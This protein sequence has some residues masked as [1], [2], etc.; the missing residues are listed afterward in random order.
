MA[1]TPWAI[2]KLCLPC[3][4]IESAPYKQA[5]M[6]SLTILIPPL[7]ISPFLLSP[8][9]ILLL[10]SSATMV[11]TLAAW[12]SVKASR[13]VLKHT[14]PLHFP[15]SLSSCLRLLIKAM[16]VHIFRTF[17]FINRLPRAWFSSTET[18]FESKV[19][20]AVGEPHGIISS[21]APSSSMV[22][23]GKVLIGGVDSASLLS[24]NFS[25][26]G[27]VA[28]GEVTDD[29]G[30]VEDV[31]SLE[32][33][34]MLDMSE[35]DAGSTSIK[36]SSGGRR[37]VVHFSRGHSNR[38]TM[39]ISGNGKEDGERKPFTDVMECGEGRQDLS[40]VNISGNLSSPNDYSPKG[41]Y[42]PESLS[43]A[44]LQ[45]PKKKA[46]SE[47][48]SLVD[49][50]KSDDWSFHAGPRE[51]MGE[52][53][54]IPGCS[55]HSWCVKGRNLEEE[56]SLLV[57]DIHSKC[58]ESWYPSLS[59]NEDFPFEFKTLLDLCVKR[60]ASLGEASNVSTLSLK[61]GS[62]FLCHL[63]EFRKSRRKKRAAEALVHDTAKDEETKPKVE[64][65]MEIHS[66]R[67][68]TALGDGSGSH[69][70]TP[71]GSD[72][73]G[74][75]C[76]NAVM[77]VEE[78]SGKNLREGSPKLS[79]TSPK[80]S[81]APSTTRPKIWIE[82][83][84]GEESYYRL[85][86][87]SSTRKKNVHGN[88]LVNLAMLIVKD[89]V[90]MVERLP[91]DP[92]VKHYFREFG[93]SLAESSPG[94][95]L[96]SMISRKVF[97]P[98]VDTISDPQW[99]NA[100][101]TSL[102]IDH[103]GASVSLGSS[104]NEGENISY[105]ST[106]T[107]CVANVK[108]DCGQVLSVGHHS[109]VAV[110]VE[111][112]E[113]VRAK[114]EDGNSR[115]ERRKSLSLP[116][117]VSSSSITNP[118]DGR[119]SSVLGGIISTTA[120]PLLPD[121]VGISY[122]PVKRMWSSPSVEEGKELDEE[123]EYKK[124]VRQFGRHI[125][126]GLPVYS[127]ALSGRAVLATSN[128]GGP[129]DGRQ[130]G[131]HTAAV[132]KSLHESAHEKSSSTTKKPAKKKFL[133][134]PL[135]SR[136]PADVTPHSGLFRSKSSHDVQASNDGNWHIE[137][138]SE[139]IEGVYLSDDAGSP[140]DGSK[141]DRDY[142]SRKSARSRS[143]HGM[144][145]SRQREAF[146][147][148]F[149][150]KQGY[151]K[152]ESEQK[153]IKAN[154]NAD[155]GGIIL[156]FDS[157]RER[158]HTATSSEDNLGEENDKVFYDDAIELGKGK[159]T[160]WVKYSTG[161]NIIRDSMEED[162]AQ[163]DAVGLNSSQSL[164]GR[165]ERIVVG[166]QVKFLSDDYVSDGSKSEERLLIAGDDAGAVRNETMD[167]NTN[168]LMEL[169][170][171]KRSDELLPS[172]PVTDV[173]DG[174][175]KEIVKDIS[176]VYEEVED[177]PSTVAKLKAFLKER[178]GSQK[179]EES[180]PSSAEGGRKEFDSLSSL[181]LSLEQDSVQ[182]PKPQASPLEERP[183]T[184]PADGGIFLNVR[185]PYTEICKGTAS[186]QSSNSLL[187]NSPQVFYCIE[188]DA[189]YPEE[190]ADAAIVG[191]TGENVE[192]SISA[193]NSSNLHGE[194]YRQNSE[195]TEA[196]LP[197]PGTVISHIVV[198]RHFQEFLDLHAHL[199][200]DPHWREAL[201]G[202]K[203]PT[204]WLNLPFGKASAS[205]VAGRR[206]LLQAYL[207]GVCTT[208]PQLASCSKALRIFMAYQGASK[209]LTSGEALPPSVE[210]VLP[211]TA[212]GGE[213]PVPRIDKFFARTV[214]GMFNTLKTALPGF[215]SQESTQQSSGSHTSASSTPLPSSLVGSH[216][217]PSSAPAALGEVKTTFGHPGTIKGTMMQL[218]AF[219]QFGSSNI[220]TYSDL[221]DW[222]MDYSERDA[223]CYNSSGSVEGMPV[224]TFSLEEDVQ[225]FLERLGK[226]PI[227]K[228]VAEF[229]FEALDPVNVED[230]IKTF[231]AHPLPKGPGRQYVVDSADED[232]EEEEL[233][234]FLPLSKMAINILCEA[235]RGTGSW[236][237][238]GTV[239]HASKV[240][241]GSFI[242]ETLQEFLRS[243]TTKD[244]WHHY[245][246]TLRVVLFHPPPAALNQSGLKE[247][248]NR[249]I[250][251]QQLAIAIFTAFPTSFRQ[252]IGKRELFEAAK[253][254]AE[255]LQNKVILKEL[256]L[257]VLHICIMHL[258][259]TGNRRM[260]EN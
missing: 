148:R 210:R 173:D 61:L 232:G 162:S 240:I 209:A 96:V 257:Q 202:L 250:S 27:Q 2:I 118:I 98:L 11:G 1:R 54:C 217:D 112:F 99:L 57:E 258:I 207:R 186:S 234:A 181:D 107:S 187:H 83:S 205:T 255:S 80:D 12:V 32:R 259:S 22:P 128:V 199:E 63:R 36:R 160:H 225:A 215:D 37:N 211:I 133:G 150:Q 185:I 14:I 156:K 152:R 198:K 253:F 109:N 120:G 70:C 13:M 33:Q 246:H 212:E 113:D 87:G 47:T 58:L 44:S 100:R 7:L 17:P 235:L 71:D 60:A 62:L 101:V 31:E 242:E 192:G 103:V 214:S 159:R 135:S 168:S 78:G 39:D 251:G 223:G 116:L 34:R 155:D 216:L 176:P 85:R 92:E 93:S 184:W 3:W 121:N 143:F 196:V 94:K 241:F 124:K 52:E 195:S 220:A 55:S 95:I 18:I 256:V 59:T 218:P 125:V 106:S 254:I 91:I 134:L 38:S 142:F 42:Q 158:M 26:A 66:T 19:S 182:M 72:V 90:C 222:D 84:L 245:V 141:E 40:N 35:I 244:M 171:M 15:L 123:P 157:K 43:D 231:D 89:F 236:V 224:K 238:Q 79:S 21:R 146:R 233:D 161:K 165:G 136:K 221:V 194:E 97:L 147:A 48:D 65:P 200:S 229:A 5:F 129:S 45:K 105:F 138:G 104:E 193:V 117:E 219:L 247:N 86:F 46:I 132:S 81:P 25:E 75:E 8:L 149:A 213:G 237:S 10:L 154:S 4:L 56:L 239:V 177:L 29:S 108:S 126:D 111:K 68:E 252:V 170:G 153:G 110:N 172:S 178:N 50:T 53:R 169:D 226:S 51:I 230:D 260:L 197:S 130:Q 164:V 249:N 140:L 122:K 208:M 74:T 166:N 190:G 144:N 102:L 23:E 228:E 67:E 243:V 115:E 188:Y 203:G 180:A 64:E 41:A 137:E 189:A 204:R 227:V 174:S 183:F 30:E 16:G 82:G 20:Q 151:L 49:S 248:R 163:D 145:Y 131:I 24:P 88:Y 73:A 9:L 69:P 201:K 6:L 76:R 114:N 119:I 206:T 28:F 175:A 191:L 77:A 139:M 127:T 167:H 179:S